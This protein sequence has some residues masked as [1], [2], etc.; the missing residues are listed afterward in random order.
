[1]QN[2]SAYVLVVLWACPKRK[3]LRFGGAQTRPKDDPKMTPSWPQ[4]RRA[5]GQSPR[6]RPT[7][8]H[9]KSGLNYT[10]FSKTNKQPIRDRNLELGGLKL[11]NKIVDRIRKKWVDRIFCGP[12]SKKMWDRNFGE[13]NSEKW[14]DQNFGG[15]KSKK[16]GPRFLVDRFF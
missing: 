10:D 3:R 9:P 14:W 12:K 13:P 2:V 1:M 7:K 8:A 6:P 11:E 5:Q 16:L 15:P 4:E